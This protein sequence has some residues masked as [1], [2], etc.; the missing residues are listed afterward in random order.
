MMKRRFMTVMVMLL[1]IA[2]LTS[3]AAISTSAAT[4]ITGGTVN[5]TK[6]LVVDDDAN[7][8]NTTMSFAIA[9]GTAIAATNSTIAVYAGPTGA[10]VGTVTFAPTDTTY[11]TVQTGD[12]V[13]LASGKKYAKQTGAIDLSGATFTE[14]GV[15]RYVLTETSATDTAVGTDPTPLYLDVYVT[16][17]D[18]GNL[19]LSS[20]VLHTSNA[21]PA[22]NNDS[23]SAD[24]VADDDAVADKTT[25]FT[26]TY[27]TNTITFS[28][29][30]A[31]NQAS[32]D[33]YFQFTLTLTGLTEGNTYTVDL[34]DADAS[35]AANPNAATTVIT[36]AVTQPATLTAPAGGTIT[37]VY[38]LKN[39]QSIS[40]L[41]LPEGASYTILENEE[42]YTPAVVVTGDVDASDEDESSITAN[43]QAAG[44]LD[45]NDGDITAAFT[46]TKDGIIPTGV[47]IAMAP[48]AIG[49]FVFAAVVIFIVAKKR[50]AS[51]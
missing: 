36:S 13:T 48:F 19:T 43:H 7:I 10:T 14:P 21:A 32:R 6:Y 1:A 41:G 30:V 12:D 47:I 27:P 16:S 2:L 3:T 44:T 17:D 4:T 24:V 35:I 34:S 40:V 8:P 39:G 29:D 49:L 18:S 23:G 26:N 20:T 46:N 42:D 25:G 33:K 31:G 45:S 38:Y 15:Y 50:R 28:K 37:Q 51:Y 11:T 9:P 22:R 5:F